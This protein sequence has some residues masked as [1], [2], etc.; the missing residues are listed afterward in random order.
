[1][2]GTGLR[3]LR[4]CTAVG[5]GVV[6]EGTLHVENPGRIA[7]DDGVVIRSTPAMSHLVTGPRGHLRIGRDVVIGHGAAIAC[8][9]QI[10]IGDGAHLGP[11]VM[12]MD[13]DFHEAGRHGSAGS[14]GAIYIGAGARLGARVTVLRGS[15]IGAGAVVDAGSVVTGSVAPAAHVAG[16]PARIVTVGGQGDAARA[17][18]MVSVCEVVASTFGLPSPLQP[19]ESRDTIAAWDSLGMLNLLLSLEQAFGVSLASEAMVNVSRVG[20]LLPVLR[21]SLRLPGRDAG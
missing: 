6:V 3:A 18:D 4:R 20:D 17:L 1:M 5:Q 19:D 14:T 11:F 13:T 15:T 2:S 9:E 16:N 8:H 12:L 7:I 21:D 10:T